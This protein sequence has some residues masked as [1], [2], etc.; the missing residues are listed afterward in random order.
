MAPSVTIRRDIAETEYRL[1]EKNEEV[2]PEAYES[3]GGESDLEIKE[4]EP[5][6][7]KRESLPTMEQERDSTVEEEAR[8]VKEHHMEPEGEEEGLLE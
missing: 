4:F 6:Q 5:P 3:T 7:E 2:D 1:P 8:W